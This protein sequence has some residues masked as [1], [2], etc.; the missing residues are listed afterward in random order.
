MKVLQV[1]AHPDLTLKSFTGQ[2]ATAFR[3]GAEGVGHSI[4]THNLYEPQWLPSKIDFQNLIL[5]TD[6]IN[7]AWPCMWEMPPAKLV[8]FLQTVFVKDF[9]FTL[10]G[11]KMKPLLN[12]PVSCLISMGQDKDLS[13][14]NLSEA[15]H[16]CGLQPLFCIF[17][18]VGP[19]LIATHAEAY[20][21]MARRQGARL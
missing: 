15:M 18:N 19:R 2:L 1:I 21:D 20:L 5:E 4:I 11:D 16:Y 7:F 3:E 8:D 12:I 6:H 9:A 10:D 13:T 17:K 14:T